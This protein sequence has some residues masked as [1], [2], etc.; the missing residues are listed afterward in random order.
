MQHGFYVLKYLKPNQSN[1]VNK[2]KGLASI[3]LPILTKP[4]LRTTAESHYWTGDG[5]P[6]VFLSWGNKHITPACIP[7]PSPAKNM[8]ALQSFQTQMALAELGP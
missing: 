1:S 5:Y 2:W 6:W 3:V 7:A 8:C 4:M